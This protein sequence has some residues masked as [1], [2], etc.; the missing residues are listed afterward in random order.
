M[1]LTIC[2]DVCPS[3]SNDLFVERK[4]QELLNDVPSV[5]ADLVGTERPVPTLQL[6]LYAI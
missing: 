4:V 1:K 2:G 3:Q 5:F 6:T